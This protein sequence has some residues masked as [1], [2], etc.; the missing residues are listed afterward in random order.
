MTPFSVVGSHK[1]TG[2]R[3]L[4]TSP[5]HV[6]SGP[7][8]PIGPN[9][10]IAVGFQRVFA[11]VAWPGFWVLARNAGPMECGLAGTAG[12]VRARAGPEDFRT[13]PGSAFSI[14]LI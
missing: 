4:M 7:T 5:L 3:L 6:D 12:P 11:R 2:K 10:K 9:P 13:G 8:G 14:P 1:N